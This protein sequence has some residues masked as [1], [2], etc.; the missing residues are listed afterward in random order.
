MRRMSH[1][2]APALLALA[3][4]PA[5]AAAQS[6]SSAASGLSLYAE[7]RLV[8]RFIWRGYDDASKSPSI[9]P[10]VE[11]TLPLGFTA[12]AWAT[13]GLDRHHDLDEADLSLSYA[14]D[15]GRWEI[16]AGY[17]HYIIPGTWT[18]PGPDPLNPL[19]STSTG[20]WFA[21][22]AYKWEQTTATLKYSRGNRAMRGNSVELKLEGDYAVADEAW[23]FQPYLALNY[24]DEYAEGAE[25]GFENRFSLVEVG[26]PVLR[27]V[28]PVKL[29]VGAHASFIP[30]PWVRALN[31]EAGATSNV[32][33][34]WFTLGLAYEP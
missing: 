15:F 17:L 10:Y 19:A 13:S 12:Y 31:A 27:Q 25:P 20:E 6:D 8:T 9:Q 30:S 28:G 1:A 33:I 3:L 32:V 14:Q 24:L 21:S 23:Q 16:G 34:P 26:V 29:I 18:E 4:L 11:L 7:T 5:P 22:L 2:A